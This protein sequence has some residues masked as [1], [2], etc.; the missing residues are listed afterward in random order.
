MTHLL[1]EMPLEQVAT[2][3]SA[4]GV[5]DAAM[6]TTENAES[7]I[8]VTINATISFLVDHSELLKILLPK[9]LVCTQRRVRIHPGLIAR[10]AFVS[11]KVLCMTVTFAIRARTSGFQTFQPL[12]PAAI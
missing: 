7:A 11:G 8:R 4:N 6:A 1:L 2:P 9:A 3:S 12:F 10:S 5:G